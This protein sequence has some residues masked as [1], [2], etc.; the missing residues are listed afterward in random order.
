M[1]DVEKLLQQLA[2][3]AVAIRK[4]GTSSRLQKADRSFD[5]TRFKA[6]QK[7]LE[8]IL[9]A[10]G[11]QLGRG[12]EDYEI[13]A[14]RLTKVQRRLIDA[15]LRR[16]NRFLYAQRHSEKLAA[17]ASLRRVAMD[18]SPP[19]VT[20]V[21]GDWNKSS[22]QSPPELPPRPDVIPVAPMV[23]PM[24]TTSASIVNS[25]IL[26]HRPP[27]APPSQPAMTQITSTGAK[28]TYPGPPPINL[29]L[30]SFKCPCCCQTLPLMF[31]DNT[32]WK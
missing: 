22:L 31:R 4:S 7:H 21:V 10:R 28:M 27:Q 16:R 3:L 1:R 29:G 2:E 5:P 25:Q 18:S 8:L 15:N 23:P 32:R 11:S 20:A 30:N 17:V 24:T 6:F 13:H 26:I 12:F 19:R 9:L 14:D